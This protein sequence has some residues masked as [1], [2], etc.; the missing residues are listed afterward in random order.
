MSSNKQG[1]D[2]VKSGSNKWWS[3]GHTF[4]SKIRRR[5]CGKC[6][7]FC[8][9]THNTFSQNVLDRV[10]SSQ[11]PK[12]FSNSRKGVPYS[13]VPDT[14]MGIPN[15]EINKWMFWWEQYRVLAI[16]ILD[17]SVRLSP[18]ILSIDFC[19]GKDR[20]DVLDLGVIVDCRFLGILIRW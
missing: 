6:D 3:I 7:F 11:N 5:W 17:L 9:S 1:F 4:R 19:R 14:S 20:T 13:A 10:S 8:L 2:K 16:R 15:Y 18:Y 12:T